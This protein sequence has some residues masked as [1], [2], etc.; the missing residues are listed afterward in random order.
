MSLRA[1][2]L[3]DE[4]HCID[5]LSWQL[6]QYCPEVELIS[7]FKLPLKALEEVSSLKPDVVFLD[8]EMPRM[9]GFDWVKQVGEVDFEIV[10]TTAYDDF[11][12]RAFQ[13]S[14]FDYLLK[15]IRK[16][17]LELTV[18][19]LVKKSRSKPPLQQLD[20]LMNSLAGLQQKPQGLPMVA[21]PT[22]QGLEFFQVAEILR[23]E[24]DNNYTWLYFNQG[25]R[26]LVTRTMK[27][28]EALLSPHNFLRVH[29][30]HMVNLLK[31]KQY[32]RG[33]GGSLIMADGTSVPVSRSRKEELLKAFE[34]S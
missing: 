9:N 13:V 32:I 1:I 7:T 23:I 3:D 6:E 28:M 16:E 26:K 31:L 5:T 19:K 2:I 27:E 22:L 8:V 18:G 29:N 17:L 34:A 20:I 21:L 10:F 11:A 33:D 24:S 15:P 14:A 4:P 30:S 25:S 12:I